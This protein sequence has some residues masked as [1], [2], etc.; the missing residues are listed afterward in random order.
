M[1]QNSSRGQSTEQLHQDGMMIFNPA[2]H[3]VEFLFVHEPG[4]FGLE[5][6]TLHVDAD[7]SIVRETTAVEGDGTINIFRQ[8]F[9]RTGAN[10]AVTSLMRQNADGTWAPNFEGADNLV[11]TRRA[12]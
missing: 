4:S 11:M 12:A 7:G 10:T 1:V 6:G 5:K 3:T 2:T 9:R 8:V